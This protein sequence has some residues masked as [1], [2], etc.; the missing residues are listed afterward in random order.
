M[1][2]LLIG[3]NGMH[4]TVRQYIYPYAAPMYPGLMAIN[5][6]MPRSKLRV[7]DGYPSP[8]TV[9]GKPNAF[10][11]VPKEVDGSDLLMVS[12]RRFEERDRDGRE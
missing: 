12:R 7:P 8:A 2:P 3:S 10:L 11:L 6:I 4:S 5:L 1:A 9:M